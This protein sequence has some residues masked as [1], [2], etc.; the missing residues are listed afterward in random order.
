M[1]SCFGECAEIVESLINSGAEINAKTSV[2]LFLFFS[3]FL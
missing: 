3:N 1:Q 2:F